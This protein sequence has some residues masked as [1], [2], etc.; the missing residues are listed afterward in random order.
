MKKALYAFDAHFTT[1]RDINDAIE[2]I[3]DNPER[4]FDESTDDWRDYVEYNG[5]YT[6]VFEDVEEE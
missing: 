5:K 1:A 3:T 6:I 4:F 2:V